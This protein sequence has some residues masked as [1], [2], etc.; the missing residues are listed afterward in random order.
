[1]KST[2]KKQFLKTVLASTVAAGVVSCSHQDFIA[3]HGLSTTDGKS[4]VIMSEGLCTKLAGGRPEPL[5]A[6]VTP[7]KINE[8]DY[9]MCYGVAAAGKNDCGTKTTACAGTISKAKDPGAWVA[10]LDGVCKQIGGRV[11]AIKK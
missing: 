3:C 5:P 6:G 7:P 1:M 2:Q 10:A 8:N 11:G 9:V 4:Y